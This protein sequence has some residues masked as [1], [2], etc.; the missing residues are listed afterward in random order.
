MKLINNYLYNI[1]I[2]ISISIILRLLFLNNFGDLTLENE[3][4]VLFNNLKNNGVLAY[5]SFEGY[6][7]PSVYMPPLYV[8]F[9]FLIDLILPNNFDLVR[10][11]LIIQILLSAISVFFFY[12][13]NLN[14]FNKKL[15]I[16]S[17]YIFI[18]FP[19]NVYS[20]LQ[21]SSISLQI[22]LS[23]IFLYLIFKI[24]AKKKDFKTYIFL[25]FISGLT[26][27]LRGEFIIIFSLTIFYL[28]YVKELDISKFAVILII[29]TLT[30]SPYLIR[31]YIVF[32]KITIT[33]SFGYN[34]WKGNN[35]DSTVE[36]SESELA[37]NTDRI[38]EKINNLNKNNL[39]EFNYDKIFLDTSLNYIN[40]NKVLFVER[41]IKKFLTFS[42]FNLNSNYPNYYHPLNIVSLVSLSIFFSISLFIVYKMKKKSNFLNYLLLN[43]VFTIIVFSI[44]FILPRYKLVILP[45]QLI[46][47]NFCLE[48][49]F[50]KGV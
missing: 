24:L 26:I 9:I 2:A 18:F 22:F 36:G 7:I 14:L 34:L 17:S 13:I 41:F 44:F 46:L 16:I 30:T 11:I 48:K 28:F 21:I 19:L 39:Y 25:G 43:L 12:K 37:F 29:A 27:L 32:E 33:K 47:I 42:F 6:L 4:G 15:S 50:K 49:Y 45:M 8:Y 38:K 31:N 1:F 5:R 40:E 20:S 23:I 10:S 35:I 3:W